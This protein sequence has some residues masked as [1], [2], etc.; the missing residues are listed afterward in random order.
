MIFDG[1]IHI[2]D[3]PV[4]RQELVSKMRSAGIDGGILI[5][6]PPGT[7]F[8]QNSA[9]WGDNTRSGRDRLDNLL[10]WT[11]SNSALFPFYWIDPLEKDGLD[12]VQAAVDSGVAGFKVICGRHYPGEPAALEVFKAIAKA[13]KPILFHSG[14]LWDGEFSSRY[15][16]PAE[17]E[18]LIGIEGLKFALAHISW[19]WCDECIAVYGKFKNACSR[20]TDLS[21]QMYIDMTP[22]TPPVYREEALSRLLLAGYDM[23]E[24]LFFGTD[25]IA[26][27]Y[28]PGW[29]TEWIERDNAIYKKLGLDQEALHNIY[30]GNLKAFVGIP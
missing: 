22:G 23:K 30:S 15:N 14:I 1:H 5:S 27:S 24:N 4:D 28:N 8:R 11:S 26:N 25:C 17:F 16:R 10:A 3:G 7:F 9:L 2:G 29:A 20:R 12:Q 21:M 18:A 6:L 19:P 13:G